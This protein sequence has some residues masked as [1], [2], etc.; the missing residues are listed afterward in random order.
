MKT[1]NRK[2]FIKSVS[3][4]SAGVILGCDN[5]TTVEPEPSELEAR[6]T[7][8][9]SVRLSREDGTYNLTL[10]G[11]ESIGNIS[12]YAWDKRL[13]GQEDY[14]SVGTEPKLNEIITETG[15]FDYRLK[16][17]DNAKQI[18]DA[19]HKLNVLPALYEDIIWF[20]KFSGVKPILCTMNPKDYGAVSEE[21]K[22]ETGLFA[23]ST[24]SKEFNGKRLA[25]CKARS[26]GEYGLD[27]LLYD[28]V[29]GE[30][31]SLHN[32]PTNGNSWQAVWSPK[33]E[34]LAFIEDGRYPSKNKDELTLISSV[35]KE[36]IYLAGASTN[37]DFVG[38]Y[39][40]WNP[41]GNKI[42]FGMTTYHIE[43]KK[44]RRISI[45]SDLFGQPIRERLHS[46]EYLQDYFG[47][48]NFFMF[49]GNSGLS[50]S[51]DGTLVA[52]SNFVAGTY[53]GVNYNGNYIFIANADGSGILTLIPKE[54]AVAPTWSPDSQHLIFRTFLDNKLWLC[55]KNGENLVDL[56]SFSDSKDKYAEAAWAK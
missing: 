40:S 18:S 43:G 34:Y 46:E 20:Y 32:T 10:D 56:S 5:K 33:G 30:M 38:F 35:E 50:W 41:Q 1:I 16:V 2:E 14:V 21:F 47:N 22:D 17:K 45:Y 25:L 39:P 19:N 13:E 36:P 28:I 24:L 29:S 44:E 23:T 12:D 4:I 55:D 37:D 6:I 27:L 54:Q 53:N 52:T 3:L 51:P 11:S 42:M 15:N 31:E 8:P 9:D 26:N 7:G 49:E 48:K